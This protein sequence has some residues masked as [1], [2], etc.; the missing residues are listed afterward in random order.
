MYVIFPNG[1][2]QI[3]FP[4]PRSATGKHVSNHRLA[5]GTPLQRQ[6]FTYGQQP[7]QTVGSQ[8]PMQRKPMDHV[9]SIV[10]ISTIA[11]II[12][13][14]SIP[15]WPLIILANRRRIKTGKARDMPTIPGIETALLLFRCGWRQIDSVVFLVADSIRSPAIVGGTRTDLEPLWLCTLH[16]RTVQDYYLSLYSRRAVYHSWAR[17]TKLKANQWYIAPALD[18]YLKKR[19]SRS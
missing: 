19:G 8:I 4:N 9:T 7:S 18:Q 17:R 13:Q 15:N 16:L 6:H 11:T 2:D 3:S 5:K 10:S 12:P 1:I 14:S